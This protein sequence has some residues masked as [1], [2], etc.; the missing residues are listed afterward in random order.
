MADKRNRLTATDIERRLHRLSPKPSSV[1][2]DQLMYLAGQQS[3]PVPASK[4]SGWIWKSAAMLST[5]VALLFAVVLADTYQQLQ[6]LRTV[7]SATDE[8]A[9]VRPA[10]RVSEVNDVQPDKPIDTSHSLLTL[11][12][13]VIRQGVDALP[14]R[15]VSSGKRYPSSYWEQVRA[16]DQPD[17]FAGPVVETDR[18]NGGLWGQVIGWGENL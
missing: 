9:T 11:R 4:T 12:D 5:S 16:I 2:R 15:T 10:N 7:A 14:A 6:A 1:D 3:C 13:T 17:K 18:V 8:Q